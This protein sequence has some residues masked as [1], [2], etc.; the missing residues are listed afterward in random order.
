LA[1]FLHKFINDATRG[2]VSAI[3]LTFLVVKTSKNT[4]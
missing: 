1:L 3:T 2:K 4:I